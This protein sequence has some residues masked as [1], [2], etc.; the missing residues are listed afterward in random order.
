MT[1]FGR[2]A[3]YCDTDTAGDYTIYYPQENI[4]MTYQDKMIERIVLDAA[5]NI[6]ELDIRGVSSYISLSYRELSNIRI[7]EEITVK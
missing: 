4:V 7:F 5:G 3:N 2:I 6:S 1:P